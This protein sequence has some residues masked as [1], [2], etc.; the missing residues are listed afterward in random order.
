MKGCVLG[1][2]NEFLGLTPRSNF[3]PPIMLWKAFYIILLPVSNSLG[4][5]MWYSN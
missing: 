4:D 2:G 3:S 5:N 1:A